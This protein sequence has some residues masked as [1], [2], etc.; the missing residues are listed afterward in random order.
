MKLI[1]F[2]LASPAASHPSS[3]REI[4]KYSKELSAFSAWPSAWAES[5]LS[6]LLSGSKTGEHTPNERSHALSDDHLHSDDKECSLSFDVGNLKNLEEFYSYKGNNR[7]HLTG[8]NAHRKDVVFKTLA[9]SIRRYLWF[10]FSK[11]YDT[12][13]L[14]KFKKSKVF[15]EFV[16]EFY[17]KNIKAKSPTALSL[18]EDQEESVWF[19]IGTMMTKDHLFPDE[20]NYIFLIR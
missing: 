8:V 11:T 14:G 2:Y 18:D 15:K 9:R 6:E 10:V 12:K 3:N 19:Y 1:I 20:S 5:K 13:L 17:N 4:F 7:L 16:W